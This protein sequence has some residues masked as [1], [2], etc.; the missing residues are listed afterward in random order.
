[1]PIAECVFVACICDDQ[2][3]DRLLALLTLRMRAILVAFGVG[4]IVLVFAWW[5]GPSLFAGPA[6]P[7]RVVTASVVEPVDCTAS[8]LV[9]TVTFTD[10]GGT[11]Q[12]QLAAC[13]HSKGERLQ[14][15]V[16]STGSGEVTV[17]AAN[18]ATGY[19]DLRQS[20]GLLLVALACAGGAVY[21][22]LVMR[23]DAQRRSILPV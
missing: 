9:E 18:T 15:V 19:S 6:E 7:S 14:V 17:R 1:M 10:G 4:F 5:I 8:T 21:A 22:L 13:G 2:R 20:V 16:E 11:Q 3:V 12:A 23:D